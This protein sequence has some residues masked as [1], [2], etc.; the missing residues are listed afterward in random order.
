MCLRSNIKSFNKK[1]TNEPNLD[2]MDDVESFN[3][4]ITSLKKHFSQKSFQKKRTH[5]WAAFFEKFDTD[6]DTLPPVDFDLDSGDKDR[7]MKTRSRRKTDTYGSSD[8]LETG[9]Q[10][11]NARTYVVGD[12]DQVGRYDKIEK[13]PS[14]NEVWRYDQAQSWGL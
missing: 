6:L 14:Y 3:N 1:Y 8:E 13:L 10:T 5:F 4:T 12:Y 9:P 2:E 7:K 11:D